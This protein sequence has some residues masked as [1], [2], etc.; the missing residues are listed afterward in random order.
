MKR[1]V[2]IGII[3]LFIIVISLF[4]LRNLAVLNHDINATL[5]EVSASV[6]ATDYEKAL[7]ILT[8]LKSFWGKETQLLN[9]Y[10]K[11]DGADKISENI[12]KLSA[13]VQNHN[14]NQIMVEIESMRFNLNHL[15]E[16][17]IPSIGNIL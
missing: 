8:E 5:D 14:D 16:S 11:H 12:V 15:Y 13:L 6:R 2:T 9:T 4:G 3:L 17:E 1:T 7:D 10:L